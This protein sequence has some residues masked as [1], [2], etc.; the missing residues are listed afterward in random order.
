MV[1][2]CCFVTWGISWTFKCPKAP[3]SKWSAPAEQVAVRHLNAPW[4][5]RHLTSRWG[6]DVVMESRK[7][8]LFWKNEYFTPKCQGMQ[9]CSGNCLMFILIFARKKSK[10]FQAN[11]RS[12]LCPILGPPWVL[13]IWGPRALVVG[14]D[15]HIHVLQRGVRVT[16][17]DHG[18]A[19]IGGL[20]GKDRG[21]L[22]DM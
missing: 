3:W 8:Q 21:E 6:R 19:G 13:P 4:D 10:I 7:K 15:G 14:R 2:T 1:S 9:K 5:L 17:R 12:F 18:D 11:L 16:Q 20:G 22:F